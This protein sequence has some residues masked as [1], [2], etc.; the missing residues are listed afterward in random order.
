MPDVIVVG[1]GLAGM[2]AAHRLLERGYNVTLIEQ[3][4][5]LGGKL[6]AHQDPD[7][8]DWHEHCYHMYLNWYH[9]FWTLMNEIEVRQKFVAQ[10]EVYLLNPYQYG[11][12][13][14][15]ANVGS[16]WTYWR[17]ILSGVA[18]PADM[19]IATISL[20]DLVSK[21]AH[22]NGLFERTSVDG[23]LT[24]RLYST[25]EAVSNAGR[26]LAEAF[27][28]PSYLSS[29]R[30]Y[31]SLV[32]YGARLPDPMMWLLTENTETGIFVPWSERLRKIAKGRLEIKTLRRVDNLE[33]ADGRIAGLRLSKLEVSP[34]IDPSV[35]PKATFD[36][37]LTVTGD[38]ILAVPPGALGKLLSLQV[39]AWAPELANVRRLQSEPMIAL[40]VYFKRR[41]P[42]VPTGITVLL[43]SKHELSFLDTSQVWKGAEGA[44]KLNLIASD[45]TTIAGFESPQSIQ[46]RFLHELSRF[47][48]FDPEQDVDHCHLQTNVGEELFVNQVGSWEFRPR[49]TC[50]IPNLFIA[51]DYCQTF[52]DVVTV[53]GAVV[54]GLM[55]A[56][57]IRRRHGFGSPIRIK[58][59]DAYPM[60]AMRALAAA[61]MPMALAT[62]AVSTAD[63]A[64]TS[65]F[66][67]MFPNG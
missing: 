50:G 21:P 26:T 7:R 1:A 55:A 33:V 64:L 63:S 29:A 15:V 46:R 24:S 49:T 17:N 47:L 31:K 32:Q 6:G 27:A 25:P 59:P 52:V 65:A 10:P 23:F 28:S 54:S 22:R 48:K 66:I 39:T 18:R 16:P 35:D 4:A 11:R 8:P 5:F 45:C 60:L 42:D 37:D 61:Q 51:G 43:E 34:T 12:T 44:T 56:E 20:A 58:Q 67:R 2:S 38:V 3:D 41:I 19:L 14:S 9:N 57:A 13:R 40:D 62:K 53:E 36:Q 30:S